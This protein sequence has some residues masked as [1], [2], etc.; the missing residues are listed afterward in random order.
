[1][2]LCCHLLLWPSML[3]ITAFIGSVFRC[4]Y[5]KIEVDNKLY[6]KMSALDK[7]RWTDKKEIN[8]HKYVPFSDQ[9]YIRGTWVEH[10]EYYIY[11]WTV[12]NKITE[13]ISAVYN[14]DR[15][16]IDIITRKDEFDKHVVVADEYD[17]NNIVSLLAAVWNH[18]EVYFPAAHWINTPIF[19]NIPRVIKIVVEHYDENKDVEGD[20][21]SAN[22]VDYVQLIEQWRK[23]YKCPII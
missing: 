14:L 22:E 21:I 4:K 11:Q 5:L 3:L 15:P 6:K 17:E 16:R 1:M 7:R 9:L 8:H 23:E 10:D 20:V 2:K 13:P 18:N 12:V 19:N